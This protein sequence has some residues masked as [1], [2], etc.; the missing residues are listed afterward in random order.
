[1]LILDLL[2]PK[3]LNLLPPET[4][5]MGL[6]IL[7]VVCLYDFWLNVDKYHSDSLYCLK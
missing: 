1:M 3:S 5:S 6:Y 4:P 7:Q 2:S